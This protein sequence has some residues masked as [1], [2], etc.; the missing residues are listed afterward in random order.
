MSIELYNSVAISNIHGVDKHCIIN[1]IS[2][3]EAVNSLK[4]T[5]LIK[6]VDII[7]SK[8]SVTYLYSSGKEN[9][10]YFI[11]YKDVDDD[12]KVKPFCIFFSQNNAYVML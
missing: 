2:K 10:K 4:N 3:S 5:D 1:V 11:G 9:Y 6:K 8:A 12:F 7:K